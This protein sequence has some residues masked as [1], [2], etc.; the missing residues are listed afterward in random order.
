MLK[1]GNV[2]IGLKT[3]LEP[4]WPGV[5]CG[6]RAKAGGSCQRP[7]VKRNR[8]GG[9]S[10]IV[11]TKAGRDKIAALCIT[12]G[13]TTKAGRTKAKQRAEVGR[14]ERAELKEIEH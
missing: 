9:K 7:A 3:R 5:R 12:H 4:D 11:Q 2:E 13:R 1:K 8:H 10:T 14:Q 6:A